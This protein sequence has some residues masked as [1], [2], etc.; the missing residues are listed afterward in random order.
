MPLQRTFLIRATCILVLALTSTA[1]AQDAPDTEVEIEIE[2]IKRVAVVGASASA[3]FGIIV[4]K[5]SPIGRLPGSWTLANTLRTSSQNSIVMIDLG[6]SMF[7]LSPQETGERLFERAVKV[8]PDLVVAIDFLFWYCYGNRGVDGTRKRTLEERMRMLDVGLAVLDTYDGPI[9]VGD[10]P[11]MSGAI[12]RMLSRAQVPRPDA[13]AALNA[14]IQAWVEERPRARLFPLAEIIDNLGKGEP[15]AIGEHHWDRQML[16]QV[17]QR[18]Q[19]HPT[20]D[21]QI[22]LI[23]VLAEIIAQDEE[24]SSRMPALESDHETLKARIQKKPTSP[25]TPDAQGESSETEAEPSS[26]A[27]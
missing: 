26:K 5:Q 3:G 14:R 7:F 4:M 20:I 19:L 17:L 8:E 1:W 25:K 6:S 2:P 27:A 9:I 24:L 16:A 12:G 18:D 21:G 15:F 23:Q 22:A 11:D 10:I 13:L